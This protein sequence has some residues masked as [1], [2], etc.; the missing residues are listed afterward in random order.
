MR[1]LSENQERR[2]LDY[3][4]EKYLGIHEEHSKRHEPG[5]KL[6]TLRTYLEAMRVLLTL[7]LQVPPISTSGMLRISLLLRLTGTV[8]ED[9][10]GYAPDSVDLAP[11]LEWLDLLDRGWLSVL[12]MQG[13]DPARGEGVDLPP[14]L[15]ERAPPPTQTD[16]TRIH[17]LLVTGTSTLEDWMEGKRK[18][19][20][21]NLVHDMRRLGYQSS[22]DELFHRTFTKLRELGP[23][24]GRDEEELLA[25][26]PSWDTAVEGPN[27]DEYGDEGGGGMSED[28]VN[29]DRSDDD[30]EEA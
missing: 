22:F 26:L 19:E 8:I 27:V 14:H 9:T 12:C 10:S 2:L 30:M 3:L 28:M 24:E 21:E 23:D 16:C 17:S 25:G 7:T 20:V 18:D 29:I 4:D 13:W 6:A 11:L 15:L 1:S 5:S